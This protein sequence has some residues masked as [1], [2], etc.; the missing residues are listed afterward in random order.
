[1]PLTRHLYAEDEVIA[2]LQFCVL[3]GRLVETAF[4][5]EE[6]IYSEMTEQ[7]LE[8]L[9]QIWRYGFGIGA[10][11]WFRRLGEISQQESYDFDELV[12]L[13]V[14]LAALG[15]RG[16]RDCTYLVL[17]GSK[18]PPDQAG[19]LYPAEG[20]EGYF[21]ACILQGRCISAWRALAHL[22]SSVLRLAANEKHREAGLA[23]CNLLD[24]VALVV[25]ALC[26][27]KGEL[28]A[29]LAEAVPGPFSEVEQA[30][31]SWPAGGRA[32]R[33]YAIPEDCLLLS[34]RGST[35]VYTSSERLLRGS[36]ERPDKLWG[37]IYWDSVADAVGGWE[38]IRNNPEV[39][40]AFYDQ[41]FPDDIPDEWSVAE[42]EKSHGRGPLQPGVTATTDL[43]LRS[44][45]G[46]ISSA[47]IWNGLEEACKN[48][49]ETPWSDIQPTR[50]VYPL[51]LVRLT[52]RILVVN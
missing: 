8:G 15:I 20:I 17:A 29:R 38:A 24:H 22:N 18:A 21:I 48:L 42:R 43:L 37:S 10:L 19:T 7:F 40:M 6:L 27:P 3:R 25:A 2:A 32:R 47:V 14:G 50:D 39:R 41:H 1:M 46:R 31:N 45:F 49:K 30:R 26:L 9:R 52:R 51:N 44:W 13:A 12:E 35:T 11:S 28:A 36:L 4:W 16:K 33:I 34:K 23:A 5:A